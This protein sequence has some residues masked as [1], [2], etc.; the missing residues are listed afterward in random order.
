MKK[1]NLNEYVE[2]N[3]EKFTKRIIFKEQESTVFVLNFQPG[4]SLPAHKHP[5]TNVYLLVL[6][7]EGAF[8]INGKEV[9]AQKDDVLVCDGNE[10]FAFTNN[11]SSNASIYVMLNK[12]PNDQYAQNI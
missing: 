12:T 5:G 8:T 3:N 7:G 11:G 9:P 1:Q 4:Q 10:E 6:Q 2:F